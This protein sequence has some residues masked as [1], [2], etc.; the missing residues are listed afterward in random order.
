M[1]LQIG[2]RMKTYYEKPF[3]FQLPWRMPVIV[4]V[5]GKTFHTFTK[6]M[7][8]PFDDKF[9]SDMMG[10]SLYLCESIHTAQFAYCQS[11]EVSI[12]LHPYKKLDTQP[13]FNNEVQKIVSV[14]AGMASSYFSQVYKREAV[15]DARVFVLPEDEVVNYFLWRQQDAT[16]NS[17]SMLAQ[18]LYHHTELHQKDSK[19]KQEM[20]FKKSG[21]NWND[22]PTHKKRGF[23]VSKSEQGLWEVDFHPPLFNVDRSYIDHHLESAD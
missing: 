9:I 5:D 17:V 15:F 22:L 8:R 20:I 19:V 13:Y 23:C 6:H 11:D 14:V 18:S 4:R 16:R 3:N 10:L 21:Q 7:E 12:L 2:D 1:K